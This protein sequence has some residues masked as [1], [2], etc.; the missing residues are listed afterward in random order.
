MDS[1]ISLQLSSSDEESGAM[2][3]AKRMH[4]SMM[5]LVRGEGVGPNLAAELAQM[6]RDSAA[7]LEAMAAPPGSSASGSSASSAATLEGGLDEIDTKIEQLQAA[8]VP[9]GGAELAISPPGPSPPASSPA[10][11][12]AR[13]VEEGVTPHT[14]RPVL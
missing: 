4:K 3:E 5:G 10:L 7:E 12:G 14:R 11:L 2:E 9:L 13:V 8:L 1:P 6:L